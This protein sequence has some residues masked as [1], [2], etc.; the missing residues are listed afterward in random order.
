MPCESRARPPPLVSGAH[1]IGDDTGMPE[2]KDLVKALGRALDQ[3]GRVIAGVKPD[4][5]SLSTLVR[6]GT[7]G[8]SSITSSTTC[9]GL[10]RPPRA[11]PFA[12]ATTTSSVTTG[13]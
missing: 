4:Q 5:A 3:T 12:R 2:G 13:S 8:H 6:R 11:A 7:F 10:R 1:G 9:G